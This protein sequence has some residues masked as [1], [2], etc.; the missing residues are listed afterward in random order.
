MST[1]G[2]APASTYQSPFLTTRPMPQPS[3][4]ANSYSRLY[5][6]HNPTPAEMDAY[7]R[8]AQTLVVQRNAETEARPHLNRTPSTTSRR[9]HSSKRDDPQQF[10]DVQDTSVYHRRSGTSTKGHVRTGSHSS[11]HSSRRAPSLSRSYSS[12]EEEERSNHPRSGP[13]TPYS[14]NVAL[15]RD[16]IG[17]D[18]CEGIPPPPPIPAWAEIPYNPSDFAIPSP[19]VASTPD[20]DTPVATSAEVEAAYQTIDDITYGFNKRVL[21]FSF[22]SLLDF[23]DGETPSLRFTD[24]NKPLMMHKEYLENLLFRLDE[25]QGCGDEGVRK[26]RKRTV[27]DVQEQLENLKRMEKMVHD[28][29]HYEKWKR[30]PRIQVTAPPASWN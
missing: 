15:W 24:H 26:A 14:G 9:S 1:Y 27:V 13:N 21:A 6:P 28:N 5:L 7:N 4:P 11:T 3:S 8:R 18:E 16:D 30:T 19:S 20:I 17:Y 25:I 10:L 22:P 23:N 29:M 12:E 2:Y